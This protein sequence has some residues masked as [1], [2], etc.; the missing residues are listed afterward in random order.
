MPKVNRAQPTAPPPEPSAVNG[1]AQKADTGPAIKLNVYG[2]S[3]TGK[4]RLA[5]TFPKPLLLLGTEDGTKSVA[6]RKKSKNG[7][8]L[9]ALYIGERYLDIDFL[10]LDTSSEIGKVIDFLAK[11]HYRSVVL[12]HAGGLQ[13]I[14][15]KEVLG[16]DN[17]P[18]ERGWGMATREAWGIIGQQVK[19]RLGQ[20]LNL[21]DTKGMSVVVV[22][23]ERNFKEE[24]GS[25]AI[26]PHVGSALTPSCA[27]WLDGSVDYICQAY[28]ASQE[29]VVE[30]Q[31]GS[32][33]Q[34]VRQATGKCEYRLRIGPH[35][36]YNTGFR[37]VSDVLP[38]HIVNPSYE[39]IVAV[40]EGCHPV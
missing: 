2:R 26:L 37:T 27:Q 9:E 34:Q 7:G 23:H 5:C 19:E 36:V 25:D 4:T 33:V 31:V 30:V 6:T 32:E 10:R 21:A 24:G 8:K 12:D 17:V 28:I 3:K 38:D 20:L 1:Q 40:I 16:L 11:N 18:M 13:G 29:S 35:P 22:A 15:T 14:I 39:K